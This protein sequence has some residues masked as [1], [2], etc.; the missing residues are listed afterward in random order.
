MTPNPE[1]ALNEGAGKMLL[2]DYEEFCK[3]AKMLAN[4]HAGADQGMTNQENNGIANPIS[5]KNAAPTAISTLSETRKKLRR[6]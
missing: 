1:S 5:K 3:K 2:E 6:L 4:I